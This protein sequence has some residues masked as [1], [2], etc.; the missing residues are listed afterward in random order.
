MDTSLK[1]LLSLRKGHW[2]Y[3]LD[4]K[5]AYL[6][7]PISPASRKYLQMEFQGTVY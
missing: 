7:I 5:D 4:L 3:S 2:A 6:Q 1:V